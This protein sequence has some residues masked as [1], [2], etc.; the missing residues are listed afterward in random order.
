M[1]LNEAGK[2]Q[3]LIQRNWRTRTFEKAAVSSELCS[4]WGGL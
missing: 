3:P 1:V 4:K 2:N